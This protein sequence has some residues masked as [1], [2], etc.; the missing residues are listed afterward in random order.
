MTGVLIQ[1]APYPTRLIF[2]VLTVAFLALTLAT[3]L[4][5][6][7]VGRQAG[8]RAA[9]RPRVSVP[10]TARRAFAGAVPT[11]ASTWMLGGLFFSV[12]GSLLAVVF[13]QANHAVGGLVLGVFAGS[14]AV[15]SVLA[16]NRTPEAMERI[17]TAT[18]LAGTALFLVA[19]STTSLTVFVL[20]AVIAGAG[21]GPAFLGAFRSLSQL[22]APHERAALI[23]A[24][25]VVSYLAFSIPAVVAGLLIT[26]VGLRSTALGY[27]A[28]VAAVAMATLLYE[29][30]SATPARR[31][32]TSSSLVYGASPARIAPVSPRPIQRDASI[33]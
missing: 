22:A 27:G 4:L 30:V 3:A 31:R 17:G 19:L 28:V 24:I 9:L 20:G 18:L 5:P 26:H 32:S 11:M 25:Y 29:T 13:G 14:A 12:G 7:T 2:A 33:A 8:V 1:Y 10:A 15:G 21:F 23:S 16:R 6:E